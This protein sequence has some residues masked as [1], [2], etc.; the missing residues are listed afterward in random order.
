MQILVFFVFFFCQNLFRINQSKISL[1]TPFG[2]KNKLQTWVLISAMN[3]SSFCL[4]N[5]HLIFF[6][7]HQVFS[8]RQ[9][10]M[11]E[12]RYISFH[13]EE[14]NLSKFSKAFLLL[15]MG[16]KSFVLRGKTV[17][18]DSRRK[19]F[20][21]L[22]CECNQEEQKDSHGPVAKNSRWFSIILLFL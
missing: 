9:N 22:S 19:R 12:S 6:F 21:L 18:F 7:Y 2:C 5:D 16:H 15:P 3:L 1:R 20:C 10:L 13:T 14:R 11:H 17:K 8:S 4:D